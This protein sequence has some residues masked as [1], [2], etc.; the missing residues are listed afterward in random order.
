MQMTRC[1]S[2]AQ[3][4]PRAD[5]CALCPRP[6]RSLK[7]HC[8]LSLER[9]NDNIKRKN[10]PNAPAAA[11]TLVVEPLT[12]RVS[13]DEQTAY[14]AGFQAGLAAAARQSQEKA[15]PVHDSLMRSIVK[16]F[17]WRFFS[18]ATTIALAMTFFHASANGQLSAPYLMSWTV[19]Q[20]CS[21]TKSPCYPDP[22][23]F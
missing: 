15:R 3:Q 16:A 6:R 22:H 11:A 20:H 1:S 2:W 19:A 8:A 14:D 10:K 17:S 18:T 7:L 23:S 13:E 21:L 4:S 9:P 12:T 5:C